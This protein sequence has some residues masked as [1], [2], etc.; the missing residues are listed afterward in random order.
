M[1]ER[2]SKAGIRKLATNTGRTI[3]PSYSWFPRTS[4]DFSDKP[5]N[6]LCACSRIGNLRTFARKSKTQR[7]KSASDFAKIQKD[8]VG[9][10]AAALS[11]VQLAIGV[12]IA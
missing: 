11:D 8:C 6:P 3:N 5:K 9:R 7:M 12:D 1:P 10:F 4:P 2:M